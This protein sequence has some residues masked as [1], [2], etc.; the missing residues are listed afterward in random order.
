M[1]ST[2]LKPRNSIILE[3]EDEGRSSNSYDF[4][5][6]KLTLN[7]IGDRISDMN[8]VDALPQMEG[9]V[10]DRSG[11]GSSTLSKVSIVSQA[12]EN[13]HDMNAENFEKKPEKKLFCTKKHLFLLHNEIISSNKAVLKKLKAWNK[14]LHKSINDIVVGGSF[15]EKL[16]NIR[17][18]TLDYSKVYSLV[19]R[20]TKDGEDLFSNLNPQRSLFILE[21][22]IC[23]QMKMFRSSLDEKL[24]KKIHILS[25]GIVDIVHPHHEFVRTKMEEFNLFGSNMYQE[26]WISSPLTK[27]L[28]KE[29]LEKINFFKIIS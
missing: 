17:K 14:T 20:N 19:C 3:D 26:N 9:M 7:S 22:Q 25:K 21:S 12:S 24:I 6:P 23:T 29:P 5:S 18:L 10:K 28:F 16:D 1:S 13:N 15:K 2:E 11:T 27:G 4:S 8:L